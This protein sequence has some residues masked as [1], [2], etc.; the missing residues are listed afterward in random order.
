MN[1]QIL[2][3]ILSAILIIGELVSGSSNGKDTKSKNDSW[4]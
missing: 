1:F 3:K 2:Q 4:F